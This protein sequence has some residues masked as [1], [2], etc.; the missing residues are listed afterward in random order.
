[1]P[2]IAA[3]TPLS[4][5]VG[6]SAGCLLLIARAASAQY[7]F[8]ILPPPADFPTG[9]TRAFAINGSGQVLGY[10]FAPGLETK[11]VVWTNGVPQYLTLPPGYGLSGEPGHHFLNDSGRAVMSL[12]PNAGPGYASRTVYWDDPASPQIVP[13]SPN[14]CGSVG[15]V[16]QDTPW[17]L[18]NLGHILI[19]SYDC[20]ILWRWDGGDAQDFHDPLSLAPSNGT[21]C[22]NTYSLR[23][24]HS[25]LND[26]DHAAL[27]FGNVFPDPGPTCP[28][29]SK[30]SGI[31]IGTTYVPLVDVPF[32]G[33]VSG[34]NNSDQLL[35]GNA[36]DI[37]FWDGSA[38][39]THFLTFTYP[40]LNDLGQVSFWDHGA[41]KIYEDGT[42]TDIVLPAVPDAFA[43]G[44][45][46]IINSVGQLLTSSLIG[47]TLGP[48]T[49]RALI[50]TPRKPVITWP[51]PADITYGT[52]LG[53]GQLN[54]TANVPGTFAYNPPAG[55]VLSAA[56]IQPLSVTFTPD[57][58]V[59][60]DPTT[61]S[62]SIGVLSAPLTVTA[63]DANKVF[64]APVPALSASFIGF[65]NGDGPGS[66]LGSLT[67]TTGATSTSPAGAYP[68]TASGVSSPNY[69]VSFAPG[70]L[71]IAP[72]NTTTTAFAFPTTTAFLQPFYLVATVAPVAPG[73]GV[74]D[75][76]V[77]FTEGASV[78]GS[79][80]LANGTA[81]LAMNGVAPGAH[82]FTTAYQASSNFTSSTF[83]PIA[84]T[85]QSVPAS[86][87]TLL[88]PV[89][90][91]QLA[92]QPALFA[93]VVVPFGGGT[94]TGT[95]QFMDGNTTLGSAPLAGGVAVFS[96]NALAAGLHAIGARYVGAGGRLPSTS[97]LQLQTIYTGVRPTATATT[98]A[99]SL[100]PSTLDQPVTFTATVTGGA[101]TGDVYFLGDGLPLGHAPIADAGESM[102]AALTISNLAV[103][104]HIVTALYLGG[105]GSAAS[106]SG[107]PAVQVIQQPGS[108]SSELVNGA[109][110]LFDAAARSTLRR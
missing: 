97:P 85:V 35:A 12:I 73:A 36:S 57:N 40:S 11:A 41:P 91:L 99:S 23:A 2:V 48:L 24:N 14:T 89:N 1:M 29:P 25:H 4:K 20:R 56:A 22:A 109:A 100:S 19:G 33:G 5:I 45:G 58:P 84:V 92:G 107:L 65:V 75:G 49:E 16:P 86:T 52:A 93:A 95:V 68:I 61:A 108:P 98:I 79:A 31:L 78:V 47:P 55:T 32:D 72:A 77:Q 28:P 50:F 106:S 102:Q 46:S 9:A 105:P 21:I 59:L 10:V 76:V 17:G 94:A 34:F 53:L 38:I 26:L 103:G 54:A 96:T 60:Y 37:S 51:K 30:S 87:F 62:N 42:T 67:L 101:T 39:V 7:T 66:L 27:D 8:Q 88:F 71:T 63:D 18:N 104:A 69:I 6:I 44:P 80:T 83:T 110:R 90:N 74:P 13:L 82:T 43:V 81:V 70:T 15:G 64:G 3:R